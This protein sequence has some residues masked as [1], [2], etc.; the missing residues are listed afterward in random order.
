MMQMGMDLWA[1]I[2]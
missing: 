1:W 2:L